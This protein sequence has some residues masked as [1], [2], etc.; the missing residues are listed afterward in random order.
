MVADPMPMSAAALD[1]QAR[2]QAASRAAATVRFTSNAQAI[3]VIGI[4]DQM[5][6]IIRAGQSL[7]PLPDDQG[8]QAF[9]PSE[10]ALSLVEALERE[11]QGKGRKL[12]G[13]A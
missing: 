8:G 5:I 12:G 6:G 9:Y 3:R 1:V 7:I 13:I 4:L 10:Q 2:Y 11:L